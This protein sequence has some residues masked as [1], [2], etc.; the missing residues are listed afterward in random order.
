MHTS[1]EL[2]EATHQYHKRDRLLG[3]EFAK[4]VVWSL[5]LESCNSEPHWY[6]FEFASFW[7]C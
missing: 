5:E 4:T 7:Q 3:Y 1:A 2:K 6:I